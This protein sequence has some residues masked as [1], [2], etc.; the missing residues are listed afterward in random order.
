MVFYQNLRFG[1][2]L[3]KFIFKNINFGEVADHEIDLHY[4][5]EESRKYLKVNIMF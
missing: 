1:F 2:C 4:N 5:H 3:I